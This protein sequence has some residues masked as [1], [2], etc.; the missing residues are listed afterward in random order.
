MNILIPKRI[1]VVDTIFHPITKV[2]AT[3]CFSNCTPP[4]P[5]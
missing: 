4:S 3:N 5:P 1:R 2:A